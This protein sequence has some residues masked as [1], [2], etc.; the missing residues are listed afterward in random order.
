MYRFSGVVFV[1]LVSQLLQA[2]SLTCADIKAFAK[3]GVTKAALYDVKSFLDQTAKKNS[4]EPSV[5]AIADYSIKSTKKRFWLLDLA[6]KSVKAYKV[7]HGSGKVGGVA[8]GDPEHDGILNRCRIPPKVRLSRGKHTQQN[9]T[10][11]GFFRAASL[12]VSSGHRQRLKNGRL[13]GGWPNISGSKNALRLHGL[14][15]GVNDKAF[16]QGVVMHGAWYNQN[17]LMGRSFG[18]P[19]FTPSDAPELLSELARTKAMFYSYVPQ[20]KADYEK[21]VQS[22]PKETCSK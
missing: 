19:A 14:S 16:K 8:H 20:C 10:R 12:Y 3:K 18:C 15:Q 2:S 6:S 9:M 13:V 11:P 1:F 7:S 17:K 21:V 5:I 22:L 4:K